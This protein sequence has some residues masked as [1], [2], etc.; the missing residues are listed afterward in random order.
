LATGAAAGLAAE[1]ED[2]A[3]V[4]CAAGSVL[5]AGPDKPAT[6]DLGGLAFPDWLWLFARPK[7]FC[8]CGGGSVP[9]PPLLASPIGADMDSPQYYFDF[10]DPVGPAT[11]GFHL[12]QYQS[13]N[14]SV[15]CT[16][17]QGII[18]LWADNDQAFG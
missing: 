7:V 12:T 9:T 11:F 4:F 17:H 13:F 6:P 3:L 8:S 2:A 18:R 10:C 1:R 16:S 5:T 15:S 14:C